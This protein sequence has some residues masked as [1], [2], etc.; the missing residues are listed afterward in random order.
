[1][2]EQH[3]IFSE[4]VR[5]SAKQVVDDLFDLGGE[6][7]APVTRI[8]FKSRPHRGDNERE[9]GGLGKEPLERVIREALTTAVRK[10]ASG[11]AATDNVG[12]K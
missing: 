8:A 11:I 7:G 10:M 6:L 5:M 9:L 3:E 2:L 1:M 4:I 12:A